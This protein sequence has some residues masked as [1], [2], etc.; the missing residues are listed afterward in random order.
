MKRVLWIAMPFLLG[1]AVSTLA[2]IYPPNFDEEAATRS[3]T[4]AD[5]AL[6]GV[7]Q[8]APLTEPPGPCNAARAGQV[9]YQV[10]CSGSKDEFCACREGESSWGRLHD[11]ADCGPL[12][13]N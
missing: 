2:Q 12:L 10:D 5:V 7:L 6:L 8:L 13:C 11:G 4:G 3:V 1:V 9:Y